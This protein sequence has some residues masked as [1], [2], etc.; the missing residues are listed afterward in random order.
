MK[1]V[2]FS[3]AKELPELEAT[4]RDNNASGD[5]QTWNENRQRFRGDRMTVPGHEKKPGKEEAESLHPP[6]LPEQT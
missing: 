5:Q 6:R 3:I 2:K 1:G 4:E